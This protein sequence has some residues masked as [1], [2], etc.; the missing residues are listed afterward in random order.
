VQQTAV[1]PAPAVPS[2]A[3]TTSARSA[4]E[5]A[6]DQLLPQQG[7]AADAEPQPLRVQLGFRDGTST[8]LDPASSQALALEQL[9][10]SLSRRD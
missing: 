10:Q 6:L 7:S 9:A 4:L 3:G 8:T 5:A 1:A 2:P